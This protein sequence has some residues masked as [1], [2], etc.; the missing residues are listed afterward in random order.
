MDLSSPLWQKEHMGGAKHMPL[1]CLFLLLCEILWN[2]KETF[3]RLIHKL[4][5]TVT[6]KRLCS[7]KEKQNHNFFYDPWSLEQ[8]LKARGL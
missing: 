6:T 4:G 1:R 3:K 8:L 2:L 7:K 5:A